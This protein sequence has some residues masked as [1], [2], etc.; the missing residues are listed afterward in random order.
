MGMGRVRETTDRSD[1]ARSGA[2]A[3]QPGPSAAPGAAAVATP[4]RPAARLVGALAETARD[5]PPGAFALVMATGI[6]SIAAH[7]LDLDLVAWPLLGLN[8]VAYVGLWLVLLVRLRLYLPRVWA[9]LTA[10]ARGPG[11]L[12]LAAGSCVLGTQVLVVAGSTWAGAALGAVGLVLWVGLS[13]TFFAAVATRRHKPGLEHGLNG[14]WL[15]AV[16]S[17]QALCVLTAQLAPALPA[18]EPLLFVALATYLLGCWLYLVLVAL[19]VYRFAFVRLTPAEFTPDHWISMGA[20]AITTL[21]GA[22]LIA[23]SGRWV[24][25]RELLPFL[26]GLSLLSWVAATW[27]IPLLVVLDV[28]RHLPRWRLPPVCGVEAW[29]RVFPLGMY[30]AATLQLARATGLDG[31]LPIPAVAMYVAL[32]AWL[33][34]GVGF[35]R[36]LVAH[37]RRRLA[38]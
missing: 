34:T 3:A 37:A 15:L 10:H 17:T 4:A 11:F 36:E 21:A 27:W 22:T 14:S 12:T 19:L 1:G 29:G 13:Y 18:T 26:T 8:V 23:S 38:P 5:L 30:T 31:L 25:L 6:V 24:F 20:A 33:L 35:V 28:W 32:L 16:V 2:H 9:D 7:L